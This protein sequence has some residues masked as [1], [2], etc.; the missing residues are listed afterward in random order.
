[1]MKRWTAPLI[2]VLIGSCVSASERPNI[3]LV[4]VDD[5]GWSDLGC[6]G[7]EIHTPTLDSLAASGLRFRHFYNEA[8]CSPSRIALL[9]GLHMQ[10][11]GL[12]PNASLPHLRT[13]NNVTAPEIL[14]ENGYRTYFAGKWHLGRRLDPDTGDELLRDPVSRGFQYAFGQSEYADG[15]GGDYWADGSSYYLFSTHTDIQPVEYGPGEF[16]KPDAVADYVLKYLDHHWSRSDDVP[17]FIYMAFNAPHFKLQAPKEIINLYTDVGQDAAE[18]NDVDIFRYET[19]WDNTRR[20]RYER[21]LSEGVIGPNDRLA[22]TSWQPGGGGVGEPMPAWDTLSA[23]AKADL[24]R[25]MAT[26]AA[27]VHKMDENLG[28]VVH[29]LQEAGELDN[30]LILF[31]ADNGGNYEGGIKGSIQDGTV[32]TGYSFPLTGD[33]LKE[34]G[35]AGEPKMN[36]GGGWANVNNTPLRFYKHFTHEGG[37]RTPM[38]VHWPN[39]IPAAQNGTWTDTRGHLIDV[40]PT[41]LDITGIS[42][43]ATNPAGY[44]AAPLEGVSFFPVLLGRTTDRPALAIEH[45]KNRAFYQGKW[46]LVVKDLSYGETDL[47]AD[48]LELYNMETDPSELN[49]LAFHRTDLLADMVESFNAWVDDH[50][51][52]NGNRKLGPV[53]V[54]LD[55]FAMPSGDEL[56]FDTFNRPDSDDADT[57]RDGFSGTAAGMNLEPVD[58]VYY[59]GFSSARTVITNNSL[60]MA[61]GSG[62]SEAGTKLNF[63]GQ[64]ILDAG[65]FSVELTVNE[66]NPGAALDDRYGGFGVGLTDAEASAGADISQPG[67]FRGRS[68]LTNGI[69][70]FFVDL[71]V[72]GCVNIWQHGALVESVNVGTNR[73]TL[74]AAF[75]CLENFSE[76]AEVSATV[77]FNNRKLDIDTDNAFTESRTFVWENTDSNHIGLS[78]RGT[79]F[80]EMDNFAVRL[81]PVTA[82]RVGTYALQSGLT[83]SDAESSAD[84]DQ[85]GMD[86]LSE[87][88]WGGDPTSADRTS[89][90]TAIRSDNEQITLSYRCVA[91]SSELH[92]ALYGTT[93]LSVPRDQWQLIN[94]SLAERKVLPDN[95][96]ETVQWTLPSPSAKKFFQVI[97]Q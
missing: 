30:T 92:Y 6:Y 18:T 77:W 88:L 12:N 25:R 16:Y 14:R 63:V 74:L 93:N 52:L 26:Y 22:P 42:H 19:G 2:P 81:L 32:Y 60:R 59:E 8:R 79:G 64:D 9:T 49:N 20:Q 29:R 90:Q 53:S 31:S 57:A 35:Q 80:V 65:G 55:P 70:S 3:L 24:A 91:D 33:R 62:M 54:E 48:A 97:V 45:E 27:M 87:W 72:T 43:P 89:M 34:M 11:A 71:D 5:M 1:M 13:D 76:G 38:I 56:L 84:P 15:S 69:A 82:A 73:G 75:Q 21:Q 61:V 78:A 95:L 7:G 10:T 23:N 28:R 37:C 85:D 39:G 51:G 67:A 36:L 46:K 58:S 40:L 66:I 50:D 96:H 41:L 17:F 4:L 83:G 86:N 94:T 47:P 68:D 44:A